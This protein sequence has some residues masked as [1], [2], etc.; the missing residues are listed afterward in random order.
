VVYARGIVGG[1]AIIGILIAL[2]L[3]AVQAQGSRQQCTNNLKQRPALHNMQI[4]GSY[5]PR[6]QRA[7]P[8]PPA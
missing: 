6:G 3:P 2:L 1:V 5:Q 8:R 7:V 4:P